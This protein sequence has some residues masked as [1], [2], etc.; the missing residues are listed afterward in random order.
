MED[1]PIAQVST[2]ASPLIF[3]VDDEPMVLE[4]LGMSLG[5]EGYAIQSFSDPLE[6]FQHF[7]T[8]QRKPAMLLAD[9]RMP[10]M[11]GMELIR[12]CKA[13]Y[14]ALKTISISGTLNLCDFKT[15][16][17]RPDR[18]INKPIFPRDLIKVV[19]ELLQ[20]PS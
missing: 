7:E 13:N 16:V 1:S 18:F 19:K 14:P 9:Y 6:A 3:I 17:T 2:P 11:T 4:V 15:F 8:A 20:E 10:G 5:D 12:R